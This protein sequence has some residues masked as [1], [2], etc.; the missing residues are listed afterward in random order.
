[1]KT[2]RRTRRIMSLTSLV[3]V[4]FL[5]LFFFALTL[6]F[7]PE[8][9]IPVDLPAAATAER[10]ETGEVVLEVNRETLR[11][12]G[13]AIAADTLQAE[14]ERRFS[15]TEA[16]RIR[17]DRELPL[18]RLVTVVDAIRQAGFRHFDLMTQGVPEQP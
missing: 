13:E 16:I 1:M 14:L 9:G 2:R 6:H 4:V 15:G 17:A 3:D 11:L 5:L 12:N 10:R 7:S 8:E 18:N